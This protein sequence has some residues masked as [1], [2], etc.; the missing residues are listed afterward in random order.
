MANNEH[1]F[2][3]RDGVLKENSMEFATR[4]HNMGNA[5]EDSKTNDIH[6]PPQSSRRKGQF[7]GRRSPLP[8]QEGIFNASAHEVPSGPNPISNR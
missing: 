4:K 7:R 2:P 5:K 1:R 8:G 6:I 3:A